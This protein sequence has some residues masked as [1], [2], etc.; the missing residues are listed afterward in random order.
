MTDLIIGGET[1]NVQ[2]DGDAKR[3]A[4]ILSNSLG[5][6]LTLWDA[7]VLAFRKHFR[8]IRYDPRGHGRS[9]TEGAPYSIAR[10]GRDVLT[11][12]DALNVE[13]VSFLGLS[14][15]GAVGL[16]LLINAPARIERAVLANTAARLGTTESWNARI[17]SVLRD[18][19][20]DN[21]AAAIERW[22][23][24]GF[25][26]KAP[27]RVASIHDMLKTTSPD[28]YAASCAALRDMD[29]R[30][31]LPRISKPVLVISGSDDP[32][33]P[34][35]D[36]DL[37]VGGIANARHVSLPA[38]HISNI[39]AAEAFNKAAL[40]F[41]LMKRP[42]ASAQP[43]RRLRAKVSGARLPF[44][45]A[46]PSKAAPSKK[47]TTAG[48]SKAAAPS[49][50]AAAKKPT[51]ARTAARHVLKRAST[52]TSATPGKRAAAKKAQAKR[53]PLRRP[54]PK[55]RGAVKKV[56]AKKAAKAVT[57]KIVAKK[58]GARKVAPSRR[59]PRKTPRRPAGRRTP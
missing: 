3:P 52:P 20:A 4:L 42:A 53:A 12:L 32:V 16:W 49:R 46:V 57:K 29:L 30:D 22:F 56:P 15:G 48:A 28:G 43:A 58:A 59:T 55:I 7:Q 51:K 11:I 10:L 8:V 9:T 41:L 17:L 6:D 19:M 36:T 25:A 13:T 1:F 34:E 45:A 18:G 5:T 38:R 44:R 35:A 21:A 26:A 40:R 39:E 33:V 14:M 23:S 27:D 31:A 50:R 2:V 47:A 54:T 37:L 24:A